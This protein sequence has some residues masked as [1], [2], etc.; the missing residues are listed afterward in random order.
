MTVIPKSLIF[1]IARYSDIFQARDVK[2]Y[3]KIDLKLK[4][5]WRALCFEPRSDKDKIITKRM[6]S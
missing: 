1:E 2:H 6:V 4:K 3:C 5:T